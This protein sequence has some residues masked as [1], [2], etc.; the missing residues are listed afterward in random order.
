MNI[1]EGKGKATFY[2][3]WEQKVH[4]TPSVD[5]YSGQ[6]IVENM[7]GKLQIVYLCD[8]KLFIWRISTVLAVIYFQLTSKSPSRCP[9]YW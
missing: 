5:L 6:I 2:T 7:S 1:H 4:M 9:A 3:G 8:L